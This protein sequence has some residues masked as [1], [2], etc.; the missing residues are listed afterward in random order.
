MIGKQERPRYQSYRRPY[1]NFQF[2][3]WDVWPHSAQQ[4]SARAVGKHLVIIVALSFK[5]DALFNK[6]GI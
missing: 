1:Q 2:N 6:L 4:V 5:I 3:E